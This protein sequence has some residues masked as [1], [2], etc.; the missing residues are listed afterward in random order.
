MQIQGG[1]TP[2]KG[3]QYDSNKLAEFCQ[4]SF[5]RTIL[6]FYQFEHMRSLRV[7]SIHVSLSIILKIGT[8]E[9][10]MILVPYFASLWLLGLILNKWIYNFRGWRIKYFSKVYSCLKEKYVIASD[11][12]LELVNHSCIHWFGS[13]FVAKRLMLLSW[14]C[15]CE[16]QISG[17][18]ISFK[19]KRKRS[20]HFHMTF[21]EWIRHW[22]KCEISLNSFPWKFLAQKPS[23]L[24][25]IITPMG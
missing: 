20:S 1:S 3:F 8:S 5:I 14:R 18:P 7:I 10:I 13:I 15:C 23:I 24:D 25:F 12:R 9:K 17:C 4:K 2:S 22:Y 16:Y 19:I 11:D 21:G 6:K